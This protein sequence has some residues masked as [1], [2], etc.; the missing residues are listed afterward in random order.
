MLLYKYVMLLWTQAKQESDSISLLYPKPR[1]LSW[2]H[3]KVFIS[4]AAL[5]TK[6]AGSELHCK[7]CVGRSAQMHCTPCLTYADEFQHSCIPDEHQT[8]WWIIRAGIQI[9][10]NTKINKQSNTKVI[11]WD[12]DVENSSLFS[13]PYA[14]A[15]I[16]SHCLLPELQY[17]GSLLTILH[18]SN[19][20]SILQTQDSFWKTLAYLN[21]WHTSKSSQLF[22]ENSIAW[23]I[24]PSWPSPCPSLHTHHLPLLPTQCALATLSIITLMHTGVFYVPVP[25]HML[26]F[27]TK[28]LFLY[29]IQLI[30]HLRYISCNSIPVWIIFIKQIFL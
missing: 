10:M 18:T 12:S 11:G 28:M 3:L 26:F 29:F 27:L 7:D 16:H 21:S 17:C 15:T 22:Q 19:L 6:G 1:W 24:S 13:N 8:L 14:K 25:L 5:I 30:H 20:L 4:S 2:L 9:A 23:P